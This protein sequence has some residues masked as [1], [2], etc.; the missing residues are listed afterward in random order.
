M[1]HSVFFLKQLP[2]FAFLFIGLFVL[3][4][5][6]F[7]HRTR[8]SMV[9]YYLSFVPLALGVGEF[10]MWAES[11]LQLSSTHFEGTYTANHWVPDKELGFR[12]TQGPRQ[13]QSIKRSRSG[14]LIYNTTYSINADGLREVAHNGNEPSVLFFGDSF[15]FGEGVGDAD[16]LPARFA[17]ISG[18]SVFNFGVHGYGAH[19]FL[20]M[21][22]TA[23]AE[24]MG[25]RKEH[26]LVVF[27]L[28]PTH[29]DRAAGR[30]IWDSDGPRYDI[31][32]SGLE[33]RGPFQR[34]VTER[35]LKKSYIYRLLVEPMLSETRDRRRLLA[36]IE[37]A[38]RI[39]ERQYGTK[40]LVIVW[41]MGLNAPNSNEIART[42][43]I[44]DNL[45]KSG[46][47]NIPVS[48][49]KPQ[50]QGADYYIPGDGHP[51][52]AA[53]AAV[54]EAIFKY[55]SNTGNLKDH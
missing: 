35:I 31:S 42:A 41:D 54:A 15:T 14:E 53:Y 40:M 37:T 25:V 36:I 21:L 9:I 55:F 1:N 39:V 22:E 26:A 43:W 17:Q 20:R 12:L 7:K 16:N 8:T 51:N 18:Y 49:I 50:L 27:T 5:L 44:R 32:S 13:V 6:V 48:Q 52:P 33:F 46:I 34:S 45:M 2:F 28:L 10:W 19:Q 4:I 3:L 24:Q 38:S 23:R 11:A 29:I 30:A 47:P